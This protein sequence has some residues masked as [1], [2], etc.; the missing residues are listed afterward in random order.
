MFR[1]F[2]PGRVRCRHHG[3]A[4]SGHRRRIALAVCMM[5]A[6]GCSAARPP[7]PLDSP[8]E[9]SAA[10]PEP[11]PAG[12]EE[13]A[14]APIEEEALPADDAATGAA[15]TEPTGDTVAVAPPLVET[16]DASTAPNVAAATRLVDA[17]RERMAAGDDGAAL[18]QLERAI[19]IDP[20]NPYAYYYLAELHF[21]HRTYDQ[22]I[23]FADRSA[24]LS[25]MRA[26]EWASRAY[27]LQGNS[28]EAVGRFGDARDAYARALNA[29]PGNLA[30]QAGLAR[31]GGPPSAPP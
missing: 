26:P 1:P 4:L 3:R 31:V 15:S 29:A 27:T 20:T 5:L 30:A 8:D 24:G 18:D 12:G 28:F 16:I 17:A 13:T 10:T 11:T 23:A 9:A 14:A 2:A 6:A 7:L 21:T 22:A 25:E 19:G